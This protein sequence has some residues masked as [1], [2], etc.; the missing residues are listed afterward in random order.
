MI[1][2]LLPEALPQEMKILKRNPEIAIR[3]RLQTLPHK[4]E[5]GLY[6]CYRR[7]QEKQNQELQS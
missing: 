6:L 5:D 2:C 3:G 4:Q 1:L 7:S